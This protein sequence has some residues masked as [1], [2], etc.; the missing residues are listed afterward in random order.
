[1]RRGCSDGRGGASEVR[2][3]GWNDRVLSFLCMLA[4]SGGGAAAAAAEEGEGEEEPQ[5]F[6]SEVA[7]SEE[8]GSISFKG[9]AKFSHLAKG[10]WESK[11]VGTLMLR[12][13]NDGSN[14]PFVTFT[15]EAVRT[16]CVLGCVRPPAPCHQGAENAW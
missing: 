5:K 2:L 9:K 14:K 8:S 3:G 10:S 7:V 1:M 15:T 4:H 12:V 11:G 6:Q 16:E 13:R